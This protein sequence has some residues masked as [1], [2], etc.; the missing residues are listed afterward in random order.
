MRDYLPLGTLLLT[1]QAK[2]DFSA[3]VIDYLFLH[4]VCHDLI[5]FLGKL[6][7]WV[8][9]L[10]SG[11]SFIGA[12]IAFQQ[13]LIMAV[14]YAHPSTWLSIY[15]TVVFGLMLAVGLLF[16]AVSWIDEI[17][18]ELFAIS[19]IEVDKYSAI[20]KETKS[21]YDASWLRRIRIYIR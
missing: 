16:V 20:R 4:E 19:K 5:G 2:E 12:V 9:Y 21:E 7:L 11:L 1:E 6:L 18:A 17:L 14:E 8:I 10:T 3:N 15:I 13:T